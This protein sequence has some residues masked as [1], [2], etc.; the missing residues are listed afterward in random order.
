MGDD[1]RPSVEETA[2]RDAIARVFDGVI[3]NVGGPDYWAADHVLEALRSLPL[4][5][6]ASLLGFKQWGEQEYKA[7]PEVG[8]PTL[9]R[10]LYMEVP[11]RS[12]EQ[13][14]AGRGS[15]VDE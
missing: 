15:L 9:T 8:A 13:G 5:Q 1:T 2:A 4:E 6:R 11:E 12:E 7:G 3:S 10:W 14:D